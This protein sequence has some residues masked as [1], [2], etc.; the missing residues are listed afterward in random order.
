MPKSV[1]FVETNFLI[2]LLFPHIDAKTSK[3]AQQLLEGNGGDYTLEIPYYSTFEALG[4]V[5]RK[6]AEF[7][8]FLGQ[9]RTYSGNL[10]KRKLI[11]NELGE[12][13]LD[14]IEEFGNQDF[15]RTLNALVKELQE[16]P[17]DKEVLSIA[18]DEVGPLQIFTKGDAMDAH[19]F[20]SVVK[21]CKELD[22]TTRKIFM[23][24]NEKEFN[25]LRHK[26]SK[27][28]ERHGLIYEETFNYHHGAIKWDERFAR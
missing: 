10:K 5:R 8:Q 15:E 1:V 14:R 3:A 11:D 7:K 22:P 13:L 6:K 25:K 18:R 16:I 17:L 27:L 24:T 19:I 9:M 26:A 2:A 4:T 28:L 23:S 12:T 21:R 20:A